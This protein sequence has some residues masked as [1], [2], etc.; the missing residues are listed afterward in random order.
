MA[1]EGLFSQLKQLIVGKPIPRI[2]LIMSGCLASRALR[3][4]LRP[5]FPQ[6][7]CDR[8]ILRVLISRRRRRTQ[9]VQPDRI[10]HRHDSRGCRLLVPPDDSCGSKWWRRLQSCED[11]SGRRQRSSR[12]RAADRLRADVAVSI[13]AGVA[14]ITSAFPEWHL[15][16]VEMTLG[17]WSSSR[18]GNLRG[19]ASPE[20][21][22][23]CPPI[24]SS[25]VSWRSSR[26]GMACTSTAAFSRSRRGSARTNRPGATMFLLLTAF[27]NGCTAMT[28]LK[29][30]R[31][32]TRIQTTGG[33]KRS[34][35]DADDGCACRSRCSSDHAARAGISGPPSGSRPW[36]RR[37]R[38][39]SSAPGR[40]VL[41]VAGGHDAHP[42]LGRTPLRRLPATRLDPRTESLRPAAADETRGP[43]G[44]FERL[45][46]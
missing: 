38:A 34:R 41:L 9:P 33:K 19:I 31:R 13:A 7:V 39:A 28:A 44:V 10:C 46:C 20:G 12:G 35:D 15:N 11:N 30:C 40:T 45:I 18:C 24:S 42:V 23:R 21:S 25:S 8:R 16:R 2:W 6:W 26:L 29:P 1:E 43:P 17:L 5:T 4:V 14:A 32:R 3:A 27:S 22:S 37:S 36:S